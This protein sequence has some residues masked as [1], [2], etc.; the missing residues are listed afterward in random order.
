MSKR[1]NRV[2][3]VYG[4]LTVIEYAYTGTNRHAVWN[5]LCTCGNIVQVPYPLLKQDKTKSCGCL[6]RETHT[7]HGMSSTCKSSSEAQIRTYNAWKGMKNRCWLPTSAAYPNY[8]GRGITVAERWK[9]FK[10]FFEDL[11]LCPEGYSLERLD[12][13]GN[14]EPGNCCWIP[15]EDQA[16]N[17][18][19]TLWVT[20]HGEKL[21]LAE[22]ARRVNLPFNTV[23]ARLRY[24][25]TEE[26]ALGL[27]ARKR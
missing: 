20:L 16:Q 3:E 12:V 18:R 4:R 15:M 19:N 11:G 5:C 7:K 9:E 27:V 13:N 24:G 21:C 23:Y 8:G 10:N 2:G 25:W 22:A 26:E 6:F 1:V 14:Y 17:K